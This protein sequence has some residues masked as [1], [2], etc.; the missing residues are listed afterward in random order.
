[1]KK[2]MFQSCCML[3]GVGMLVFSICSTTATASDTIKMGVVG[4]HSGDLASYGIPTIKAAE[5]VIKK[6][7]STG[8][9]LGKKIELLVEDDQCKTEIATNA[10]TKLLTNKV[11]VVLGHICSGPCKAALGIYKS[12]NVIA[13]SPSATNT[14]LTKSG[15]YPNFF[16]TI[17][18]DDA[19]AK[20]QIDFALNVLKAKKIAIVHDK[21]DYGKGLAEYAK[22]FLEKDSRGKLVLYEGITPGAVDYSAIIN[23]VKRSKAEVLI[24]G[25]FHPEASKLV[26]LMRK[27][28]M[29]TILL[30]DDGVMDNTFIKI[31]GKYAE[32]V[33]ATG[34]KDTS[35]NKMAVAAI[36]AHRKAYGSD[37]GAFFLN[38]YAAA[39]ALME[40]IKKA[41]SLDYNAVSKTLRSEYF[42]TP[43]GKISFNKDGDAVGVGFAVFQV[44]N[45]VYV[46]LK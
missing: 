20:T 2:K 46:E 30:S 38:A 37:P 35:K 29:K 5:L 16:R 45:G 3:L 21:G 43:L 23:K 41:G 26:Q 1:M 10:A 22:T 40:G 27:K 15:N 25:G 4:A 42:E 12:E 28:R 39:T 11:N 13:M 19:Q 36:E 24:Y 44:Q 6:F 7:N 9:I 33:Y 8:G 14:E 18:P 17:A 31:A 34:P 32:G